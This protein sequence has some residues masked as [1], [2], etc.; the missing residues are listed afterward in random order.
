MA[1]PRTKQAFLWYRKDTSDKVYHIYLERDEAPDRIRSIPPVLLYRCRVEF[2]RRG[3]TLQTIFKARQAQ[4]E[5]ADQAFQRTA[6]AQLKQGYKPYSGTDITGLDRIG[7]YVT[8]NSYDLLDEEDPTP[9]PKRGS[10]KSRPKLI[11]P[12]Q[13]A[14]R[15][16]AR[17]EEV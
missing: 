6:R 17:D 4:Y 8:E 11:Q 3:G 7:V 9:P 10:R 12:E 16:F 5:I 14:K 13:P 1:Q 2:G 15:R